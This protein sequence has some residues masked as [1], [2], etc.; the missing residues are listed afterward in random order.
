MSAGKISFL[1]SSFFYINFA[2]LHILI[3]L[4]LFCVLFE[5][6]AYALGQLR[7]G[8]KLCY[9]EVAD[10]KCMPANYLGYDFFL[11]V[12]SEDY[13]CRD[14]EKRCDAHRSK[15]LDVCSK[16]VQILDPNSISAKS[17]R[18]FELT[19]FFKKKIQKKY[20]MIEKS[21]HAAEQKWCKKNISIR[22]EPYPCTLNFCQINWNRL[23]FVMARNPCTHKDR[24]CG[25]TVCFLWFP[26]PDPWHVFFALCGDTF[27]LA[28]GAVLAP[29]CSTTA[30]Y[31]PP[32]CSSKKTCKVAKS[33]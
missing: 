23:Y 16:S 6:P 18:R 22:N 19:M 10:H 29:Q 11:G 1:S 5:T 2:Q 15:A 32:I 13:S 8:C 31:D 30:E 9:E 28:I 14:W 24:I 21:K 12:N 26:G 7:F 25:E 33:R 27:F 17:Y 4:S 20:I 3:S